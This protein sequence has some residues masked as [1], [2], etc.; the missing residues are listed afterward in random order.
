MFRYFLTF[1]RLGSYI[2][3]VILVALQNLRFIALNAYNRFK[4]N[5]LRHVFTDKAR[6]L[7]FCQSRNSVLENTNTVN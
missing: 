2:F 5:A 1:V 4:S 3:A 7:K 6:S